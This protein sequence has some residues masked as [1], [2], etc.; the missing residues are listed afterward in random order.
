MLGADTTSVSR[1][2]AVC[3]ADVLAGV[4]GPEIAGLALEL[5]HNDPFAAVVGARGG[6]RDVT[7]V[8]DLRFHRYTWVPSCEQATRYWSAG[9]C[10][11]AGR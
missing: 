4:L 1:V 8:D 11:A 5:D 7:A 3:F 10:R 6:A 9:R 2:N